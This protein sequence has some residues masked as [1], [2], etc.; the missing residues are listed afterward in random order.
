[1]NNCEPGATTGHQSVMRGSVRTVKKFAPRI[2]T[3]GIGHADFSSEQRG[4][5]TA[6]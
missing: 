6:L 4:P 1:M 3:L 5:G 2:K